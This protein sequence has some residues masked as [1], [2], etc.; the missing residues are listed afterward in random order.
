VLLA[1]L[2]SGVLA[3]A[4]AFAAVPRG[5]HH[6]AGLSAAAQDAQADSRAPDGAAPLRVLSISPGESPDAVTATD[7]VRVIF[8]APLAAA[9][10]LPTFSPAVAGRWHAAG[11]NAIVFTP[12]APL[13]LTRQVTLQIPGGSSGVRSA[14][15]ARLAGATTAVFQAGGWTT[16]RL[17][18]LLAQLSYLPLNWTPGSGSGTGGQP[19]GAVTVS[20]AERSGAA[21]PAGT[22]SWQG[23]YPAALTSLWQPGQPNVIL[24]GAVMAFQSDHGL[25]MTGTASRHVWR[26]LLN[27]VARGERN[28]HG[29]T[30]ALADK[31]MPE[32]MTVWHDGYVV[33]RGL[34]STGAAVTPTPDGT[35]PVYLRHRAQ[36]M[37]GQMPDGAPYAD[38][39]QFV[40]YF[41]GDYAVHSMNRRAFGFPQS[42]GCVELPLTEARQ[43]WPYLSYGSLVTVTG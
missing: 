34:A 1:A 12:K 2:T 18:Q 31:A 7:P 24:T 15:G 33:S 40:S 3:A 35:F 13:G 21:A 27:A 11:G 17:E 36:V 19:G 9:S 30:Y 22:F 38:P 32:T 25:P 41:K 16:L 42:L 20:Y 28:P 37:R 29:Y 39:V 43:V 8:S 10:P 6:T 23:S 5:A 14:A 26:V 4:I